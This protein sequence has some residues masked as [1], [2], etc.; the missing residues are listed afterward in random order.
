MIVS[1]TKSFI[2]TRVPK[3]GSTSVSSALEPY[4]RIADKS[5]VGTLARNL[6]PSI[7][8]PFAVNFRAHPHWPLRAAKEIL[9]SDFFNSAYKFTVVRDP[10]NWCISLH[11]HFLEHKHI[12]RFAELYE[13][14]YTNTSFDYFVSTLVQKPIPPQVGMIAGTEGA[15]MVD[16]IVR[17]ENID[18]EVEQIFARLNISP[19]ISEKNKGNY[20][21]VPEVSS[22]SLEIIQTIY[23]VDYLTF[24]YS[25][26]GEGIGAVNLSHSC[27]KVGNWL[28]A[29]N[30]FEHR[31]FMRD[32][33]YLHRPQH[34]QWFEF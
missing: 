24:G 9:P 31:A 29:A 26:K 15:P 16:K 18:V 34:Q 27:P 5:L 11:N 33:R 17:L 14:I 25:K 12:T 4:R 8:K 30:C 20:K 22:E 7:K 19:Q 13:D 21:K 2:Y 32:D 28:A 23:E 3:T 6:R 1:D 10:L